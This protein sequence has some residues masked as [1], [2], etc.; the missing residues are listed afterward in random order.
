MAILLAVAFGWFAVSAIGR[1]R[2]LVAAAPV[3][4]ADR[5]LT[6]L[7]RVIRF[8]FGQWRMPRYPLVGIAHIAIFYG[9]LVLLTRSIVLWGRGFD[10]SF[11]LFGL[12]ARGWWLGDVYAFSKDVFVFLVL[13]ASVVLLINRLVVRPKRMTFSIE[14][15]LILLIIAVM[16]AAE[17]IYDIHELRLIGAH[18]F[19]WAMPFAT[20]AASV[21]S[22]V[23]EATLHVLGTVGF[24]THAALVL[25]FLNILPHSKHF[26]IIT[27]LPNVYTSN[28]D[29]PGRLPTDHGVEAAMA[30]SDDEL[31][32]GVAKI[33]EH[34]WK[35]V[36]DMFTCTEC[37]RCSDR[38]PAE[39]TGKT[40]SPKRYL[41]DLRNHLYAREREI[42]WGTRTPESLPDELVPSV[43]DPTVLW[44]CTTCRACEQECPLMITYV[45]KIVSQR[46]NLV[47]DKA[48]MPADLAA[49]LDGI[50]RRQNPWNMP[51]QERA[52]WADGL[53]IPEYVPGETEYLYF[54]GCAASYNDR[55][56]KI[57]RTLVKLLTKAG[58]SFGT[59]GADEPCCG[60]LARRSGNEFLY[61][62]IAEAN[63]EALNELQ[64]NKI[65]TACPH[66]FN[67]LANEYTAFGLGVEEVVHHSILLSRLL[68]DGR[69]RPT[70]PA[71]AFVAYHDA[72]YLGRYNNVYDEPR[73]VLSRVPGLR[74]VEAKG[75]CRDRGMCCGGGGGKYFSEESNEE[76]VGTL[77]VS[78]LLAT[79]PTMLAAACPFCMTMLED[80]LKA[81]DRDEDVPL[82][83]IAEVLARSCGLA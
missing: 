5:P 74:L 42:S 48:D 26:H 63:V 41:V 6:R 61:R 81:L 53:E 2:L 69:L 73:E 47:L 15:V 62:T 35:S 77:R 52:D 33:T 67:T 13:I 65:V 83:D 12:L 49:A 32:L 66:G 39:R 40:L 56:R 82:Y 4:R 9:F 23:P 31:P 44:D 21:F 46:R 51:P 17:A 78:Q 75:E 80:G 18:G 1:W 3:N 54:V 14:G 58:V 11:T 43:V 27:A 29:P 7:S 79:E 60:D 38:C 68:R 76:R 36:L 64:V 19:S 37:G 34:T 28:L 57:A 24:W 72:C 25:L 8:A 45:D 50:E 70:Q 59:L 16:M 71:N 30:D 10:E 20:S 22:A 55:A